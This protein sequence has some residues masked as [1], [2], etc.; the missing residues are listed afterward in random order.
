MSEDKKP[1]SENAK[2]NLAVFGVFAVLAIVG[3]FVLSMQLSEDRENVAVREDLDQRVATIVTNDGLL[4]ITSDSLIEDSLAANS[5]AANSLATNSFPGD[6]MEAGSIRE[7]GSADVAETA[8]S[9]VYVS[10]PGRLTGSQRNAVRSAQTYLR[11]AGFSRQ[12]LID[13]LSSS[14]GDGYSVSD[15]IVAI[16]SLSVDWDENA[17]RS[18]KE[19][20]NLMGFS[21]LGLIEQLSS[22]AGSQY[23]DSQARY[24]ARMAGAC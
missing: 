10:E 5:L 16:D 23:T 3:I 17:A 18:A 4:D 22:S 7:F 8:T 13:Q 20:V 21:C 9:S 2:G 19:Y 24:G 15:A 6:S 12:G 1:L 14:A 11:I